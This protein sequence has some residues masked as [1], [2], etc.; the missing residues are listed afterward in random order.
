MLSNYGF[1]EAGKWKLKKNSTSGV[2]FKLHNFEK[3]RVVYAF[4][5][6][7]KV[8]YVGVCGSTTTT[9]EKRMMRYKNPEKKETAPINV[10]STR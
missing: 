6:E 9:L 1:V 3:E 2:T 7:D 5:V 4:V 10:L 8:K